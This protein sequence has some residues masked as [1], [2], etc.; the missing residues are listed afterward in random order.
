MCDNIS[1]LIDTVQ[2][3]LVEEKEKALSNP[4][5]VQENINAFANNISLNIDENWQEKAGEDKKTWATH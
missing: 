1:K 2:P 4:N 3:G 5:L